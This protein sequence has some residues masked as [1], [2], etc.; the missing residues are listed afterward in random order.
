MAL[1]A[2]LISIKPLP[3]SSTQ[4]KN[5]STSPTI[6]DIPDTNEL[7]R[8]TSGVPENCSVSRQVPG[9]AS[10]RKS[11][12]HVFRTKLRSLLTGR[13]YISDQQKSVQQ[14]SDCKTFTTDIND[15]ENDLRRRERLSFPLQPSGVPN[16]TPNTSY[17]GS[18]FVMRWILQFTGGKLEVTF[19][20]IFT[21][22]VDGIKHE[23][24]NEPQTT[25]QDIV[26]TLNN[27][28]QETAYMNDQKRMERLQSECAKLYTKQS[29]LFR[30]VNIA[31]R[32]NDNTKL[33]TLGPFCYLVYNYIG[34]HLN[35]YLSVR[36]RLSQIFHLSRS[37]P[38]T[39]Y[40]GDYVSDVQIEEYQQAL[41]TK[42]KY[43]KWLSFVSTSL[44][45]KVAESFRSNVLYIIELQ[46]H[47]SDDQFTNLSDNTYCKEEVEIL[48]RPGVQFQVTKVESDASKG[49]YIINVS[50]IPSYVSNLR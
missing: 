32:E 36:H 41:S 45:R 19:D 33:D 6:Y 18:S 49:R 23:G 11:T 17:Y 30:V 29:Y 31:L 1:P 21:P 4:T 44:D 20:N 5:F 2:K 14:R 3:S 38:M 50:I 28:R 37:T 15:S 46:R 7:T 43:F 34:R 35:N 39:V 26:N 22:L 47:L 48:L 25:V 13:T 10:E 9:C 27:V 16:T 12:N 24:Q 42:N 8:Y 40:R